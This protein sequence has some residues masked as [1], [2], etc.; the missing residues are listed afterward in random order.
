[1]LTMLVL[2][3]ACVGNEIVGSGDDRQKNDADEE[4]SDGCFSKLSSRDR[5]YRARPVDD[6]QQRNHYP[7]KVK[8]KLHARPV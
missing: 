1:M 6:Q 7:D 3:K 4:K 2:E 8:K 5:L